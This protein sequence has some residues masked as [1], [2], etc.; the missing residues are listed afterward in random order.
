MTCLDYAYFR[1][2]PPTRINGSNG[3]VAHKA[4]MQ[5]GL[6]DMNRALERG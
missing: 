1:A 6:R 4:A 2:E 5:G 3:P